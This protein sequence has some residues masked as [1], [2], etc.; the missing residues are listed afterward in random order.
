MIAFSSELRCKVVLSF[1]FIH[2][3]IPNEVQQKLRIFF[4]ENV[5]DEMI[6]ELMTNPGLRAEDDFSE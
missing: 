2:P 3:H 6:D 1:I 4:S 5:S